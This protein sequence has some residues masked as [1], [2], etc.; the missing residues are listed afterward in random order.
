ML[1]IPT[2]AL[3]ALWMLVVLNIAPPGLSF[4]I[5]TIIRFPLSFPRYLT[6]RIFFGLLSA[7]TVIGTLAIVSA[8]IG[9]AIANPSLAPWSTL[10]LAAF[11]LANIFFTRMVLFCVV[12][13]LSTRR[14]R[15]I[16]TAFFLFSPPAFQSII[17][18]FNPHPHAPHHP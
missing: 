13:W 16:F 11:A 5:N 8:D 18:N 3:F 10:V 6:A 12:R 17:L 14:T 15:E 2:W 4:D 7:S 9:I 1:P